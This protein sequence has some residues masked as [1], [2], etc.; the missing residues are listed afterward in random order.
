MSSSR[1]IYTSILLS[2]VYLLGC[3]CTSAAPDARISVAAPPVAPLC[4]G[5][6]SSQATK[7][8]CWA[9]G[10]LSTRTGCSDTHC[11]NDGGILVRAA[12]YAS[13][14]I[15]A[16]DPTSDALPS[17]GIV[18]TA[19]SLSVDDNQCEFHAVVTPECAPGARALFFDADLSTMS[20]G[21]VPA[22][23]KPYI[24]AYSSVTHIAPSTGT[25]TEQAPGRYRIGPATFDLSGQWSVTLHFFGTCSDALPNS[26]HA[27]VTFTLDVP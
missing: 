10:R 11:T 7:P 4:A 22:G 17:G 3:S 15:A 8:L 26:P 24:E 2:A 20:G 14:G 1:R 25:Y 27:H 19:G 13:C 12:D 5:D 9:T 16:P 6:A 21:S 18:G 23:A